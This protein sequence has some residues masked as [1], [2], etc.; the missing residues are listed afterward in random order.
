M[1][2]RSRVAQLGLLDRLGVYEW[3]GWECAAIRGAATGRGA[4]RQAG[5]AGRARIGVPQGW[6]PAQEWRGQGRPVEH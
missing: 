6:R 5:R 4:E 1:Q 2:L 3:G